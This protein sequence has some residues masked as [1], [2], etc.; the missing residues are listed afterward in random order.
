[1]GH[2]VAH[3]LGD[4]RNNILVGGLQLQEGVN[5][6]IEL[7]QQLAIL[8]IGAVYNKQETQR[9]VAVLQEIKNSTVPVSFLAA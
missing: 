2:S 1:V 3:T 9:S 8:L 7:D 6:H 5:H 4:I